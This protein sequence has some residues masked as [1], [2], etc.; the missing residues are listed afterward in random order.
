MNFESILIITY[1]RSG[2]TLLQG[3]L[4]AIDGVLIRGENMNMCFHMFKTY[5][6]ILTSKSKSER[7]PQSPFFGA[8]LLDEKYF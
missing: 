1:G 7:S 2:S 3:V 6:A 8:K 4:N 5:Q